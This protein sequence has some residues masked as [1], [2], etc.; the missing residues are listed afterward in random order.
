ML[1][2]AYQCFK[3][4]VGCRGVERGDI[5]SSGLSVQPVTKAC[6]CLSALLG[7]TV[8]F[9]ASICLHR[10]PPRACAEPQAAISASRRSHF[11]GLDTASTGVYY[12]LIFEI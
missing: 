1:P 4:C 6:K 11:S 10:R 5:G 7:C 12:A 8:A 9:S 2:S 3:L